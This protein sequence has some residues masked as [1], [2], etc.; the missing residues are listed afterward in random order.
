[1]LKMKF[2]IL[3]LAVIGTTSKF[4]PTSISIKEGKTAFRFS[5]DDIDRWP[6]LIFW[7]FNDKSDIRLFVY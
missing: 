2:V 6:T 5:E 3:L 4:I 1:M 7:L